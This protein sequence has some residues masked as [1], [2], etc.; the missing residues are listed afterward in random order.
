VA[1]DPSF[2]HIRWDDGSWEDWDITTADIGIQKLELR[3]SNLGYQDGLAAGS[4]SDFSVRVHP[5]NTLSNPVNAG[6]TQ[7]TNATWVLNIDNYYDSDR[8]N[9]S[10]K[11]KRS[12]KNGWRW[13]ISSTD[14]RDARH[15]WCHCLTEGD[16]G[17]GGVRG[18]WYNG[19]SHQYPLLQAVDDFGNF[20]GYVGVG[21]EPRAVNVQRN[22]LDF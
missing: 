18:I 1:E 17:L 6:F 10:C 13:R 15:L 3:N 22:L 19:G 20:R 9:C 16:V 5:Q 8:S 2:V 7:C 14:R 21:A 11:P 12:Y 4:N